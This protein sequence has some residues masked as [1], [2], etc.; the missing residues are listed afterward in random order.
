MEREGHKKGHMYSENKGLNWNNGY[1][2]K[3]LDVLVTV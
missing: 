3:V 2:V 1:V